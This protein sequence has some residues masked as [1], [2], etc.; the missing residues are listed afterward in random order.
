MLCVPSTPPSHLTHF[1]KKKRFCVPEHSLRMP[2]LKLF[3]FLPDLLRF[4]SFVLLLLLF[5]FFL[6]WFP[7]EFC[8]YFLFGYLLCACKAS[9]HTKS[10]MENEA[11]AS[12]FVNRLPNFSVQPLDSGINRLTVSKSFPFSLNF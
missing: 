8:V 7:N 6:W 1:F 9:L 12:V 2:R 3:T 5:F 4:A 11:G 10:P